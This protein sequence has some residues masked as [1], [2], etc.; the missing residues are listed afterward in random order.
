MPITLPARHNDKLK[1]VIERVNTDR[2]LHQ[3][4]KCSNIN[5]VDRSHI[6]DHGEVHIR[7]VSNI[8]L[9]ICRLLV[10]G[11]VEMGIVTDY[12]MSHD[13]AEVVVVLACCLHDLGISVHRHRHEEYSLWLARPT[14]RELL[15]DIYDPEQL[16]IMQSEILHCIAAHR[17][18]ET[19]LTI[20]SGI[21]KVADA[22]DITKGRSRIPFQ[23]GAVNIHAVSAA[24][25]E[26]VTLK[27]GE[28]K[29]VVIEI[30]MNNSA[31]IFQVD[32]LLKRK[33]ANSTLAQY[34]QV[35]ARI[36]TATEKSLID[37]YAI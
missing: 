16:V 8:A 22:L 37:V 27:K 18:D 24:A 13:D 14:I 3:L 33:L 28:A 36:E 20:E 26:S 15:S 11:G 10:D 9:K 12:G 34:V 23:A 17:W 32:E 6:S 21:V 5:A 35:T 30:A 7:I 25:I 29:P 2:E 31:G 4:W 1:S 19:C